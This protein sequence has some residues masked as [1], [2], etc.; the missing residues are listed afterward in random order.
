MDYHLNWIYAAA[1]LSSP[2][3]QPAD[4]H[5]NREVVE[6]D[7]KLTHRIIQGNQEDIDLVVAFEDGPTSHIVL[8]EAKGVTGWNK[9]QLNSKAARLKAIFGA[10]GNYFPHMQPHFVIVSPLE[11][12]HI[13]PENWPDWMK[14]DA[15][16]W[17]PMDVPSD[18]LIVKR[19]DAS[20]LQWKVVPE[21]EY[22]SSGTNTS[23]NPGVEG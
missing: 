8:V 2:S 14:G 19:V 9:K 23:G 20:G 17:L 7:D 4:V 22:A 6:P 21:R 18:L 1:Y 16:K 11:S 12:K 15:V 10:L 3:T 13:A 5:E